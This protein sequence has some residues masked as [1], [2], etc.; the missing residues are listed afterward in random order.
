M[1]TV[2][3][4]TDIGAFLEISGSPLKL[5]AQEQL[6]GENYI[7]VYG[8]NTDIAQNGVELINKY[9]YAKTTTPFGQ[10]LSNTNRFTVL[11]APGKYYNASPAVFPLADGQ[12]E[13]STDYVDVVSLTGNPDV[14]LSGI[15][16]GGLSYIKGMNTS[17]AISLGGVQAGFNLIDSKP[18]QKIENCI[19][20]NYSFG[21]GGNVDG[22]FINC[23]GGS[24]SFASVTTTTP[25][26]GI[27]DLGTGN[28]GGIFINCEA[29][30]NS[31]G[32]YTVMT[33]ANNL[34]GTFTNCKAG[35]SSFGNDQFIMG[36]TT[37]SGLFTNCSAGPGSF[38][39]GQSSILAGTFTNCNGGF[40]SFGGDT[41]GVFNNCESGDYSF[42]SSGKVASGI[43]TNCKA[44]NYSFGPGGGV[45]A[46]GIFTYCKAGSDSFG[47]GTG[48]F[49][50]C[51]AGDYSFGA[52]NLA[53]GIY[54][55]CIAGS[56]S[57]GTNMGP[58]ISGQLYFCRLT[59]GTFQTVT[60]AGKTVYCVDG[61][62]DPN[63]QGFA[64]QNNL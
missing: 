38:G 21:W 10:G 59:S 37:L 28:I 52:S 23:I 14:F 3:T 12:F 33:G 34:T 13:F 8:N 17:E 24:G 18:N 46:T 19:G 60:G 5:N 61:N 7:V 40:N 43:Y 57:F 36:G 20:G 29:G 48:T 27:T 49:T 30:S 64:P 63:N 11:V 4:S 31:F 62:G 51:E 41:S 42:S 32:N 35:S 1:A 22:T 9:D 16:V 47:S 6:R 56:N 50:N 39:G 54:N 53:D 55:K 44:G 2:I 25:P 26:M 45:N 58:S 15:S